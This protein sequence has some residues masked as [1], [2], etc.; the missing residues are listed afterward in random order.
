MNEPRVIWGVDGFAS[1]S[2]WELVYVASPQTGEYIASQDVWISIGTG[3]S[4]GAYLDEPMAAEPGKAIVRQDGAWVAVDDYRGQTAYNKQTRQDI[5]IDT[6]GPLPSTL[7]LIP[8]SSQFDVWDEQL[9]GWIKD[10]AQEESWLI[11]QASYQRQHLMAEASQ[12]IAVLIDALDPAIISDP[13]DDDQVKLIAWKAYRVELSKIDQ[14]NGYPRTINW[15]AK[16][17]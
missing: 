12:E 13:S 15:P 6:L 17:Q 8:P 5:M 3:L 4:A 7:T 1:S 14:Q 2:G 16:P 11:E 10:D 9:G